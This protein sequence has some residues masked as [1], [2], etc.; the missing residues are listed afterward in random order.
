MLHQDTDNGTIA[1]VIAWDGYT[2]M[3]EYTDETGIKR[4]H[5]AKSNLRKI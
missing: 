4:H 1:T 3:V 5:I 2:A